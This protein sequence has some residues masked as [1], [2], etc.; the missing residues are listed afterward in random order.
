[1]V[2]APAKAT[3]FAALAM[4]TRSVRKKHEEPSDGASPDL[5]KGAQLDNITIS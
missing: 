5:K 3:T 2:I 1:M 4:E